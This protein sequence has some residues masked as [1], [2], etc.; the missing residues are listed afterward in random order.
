VSDERAI[1][2]KKIVFYYACQ[3]V[4]NLLSTFGSVAVN[5]SSS[6]IAFVVLFLCTT[7]VKVLFSILATNL[8]A[9]RYL[10]EKAH[11][12]SQIYDERGWRRRMKYL[13]NALKAE[14]FS[15][16]A[17]PLL[18][19]F[20]CPLLFLAWDIWARMLSFYIILCFLPLTITDVLFSAVLVHTFVQPI[21]A[22]VR[23][24]VAAQPEPHLRP[25]GLAKLKI[26][27]RNALLGSALCVVSSTFLYVNIILSF[28]FPIVFNTTSI[29]ININVVGINADSVLNDLG[30]LISTGI[31]ATFVQSLT[32]K[33]RRLMRRL[34]KSSP[35]TTVTVPFQFDSN[36]Y[37]RKDSKLESSRP[38]EAIE[39]Q[40]AE[41]ISGVASNTMPNKATLNPKLEAASDRETM[42]ENGT[43]TTRIL[44]Q[45]QSGQPRVL[46]LPAIDRSFETFS[47][48]KE[49]ATRL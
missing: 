11:I 31:L 13:R 10:L 3:S 25:K 27:Y 35:A 5:C 20:L 8:L 37:E 14:V 41:T 49:E 42:P 19:T 45:G 47:Q 44:P 9:H 15:L 7:G 48:E 46:R 16:L 18:G 22:S 30:I 29:W 12:V 23:V 26:T 33:I 1:L 34:S 36:A 24:A 32:K 17:Y 38:A 40:H 39:S 21:T 2:G 6:A 4:V 28:I 43:A